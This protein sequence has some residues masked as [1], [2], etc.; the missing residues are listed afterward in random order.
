MHRNRDYS[1]TL[2]GGKSTDKLELPQILIVPHFGIDQLT[3]TQRNFSVKI[4]LPFLPLGIHVTADHVVGFDQGRRRIPF[5][6]AVPLHAWPEIE[7][8]PNPFMVLH[9]NRSPPPTFQRVTG[10]CVR[11]IKGTPTARR[12]NQNS[13]GGSRVQFVVI[14]AS[15]AS[16]EYSSAEYL[17]SSRNTYALSQVSTSPLHFRPATTQIKLSYATC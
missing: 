12:W 17:V 14:D 5:E 16:Y 7:H 13:T 3:Q 8:H 11:Q 2:A 6:L 15:M 1:R 9:T 10:D 4:F